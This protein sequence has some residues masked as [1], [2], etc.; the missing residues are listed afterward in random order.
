MDGEWGERLRRWVLLLGLCPGEFEGGIGWEMMLR[1]APMPLL[2]EH[3]PPER[4]LQ[5]AARNEQTLLSPALNSN[6]GIPFKAGFI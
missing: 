3:H 1:A 2:S 6:T 4:V 5:S